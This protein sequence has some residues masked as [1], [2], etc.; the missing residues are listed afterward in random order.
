MPIKTYAMLFTVILSIM[1]VAGCGGALDEAETFINQEP[2]I[3][4]PAEIEN[5]DGWVEVINSHGMPVMRN[6][7][8]AW[9]RVSEFSYIHDRATWAEMADSAEMVLSGFNNDEIIPIKNAY[10]AFGLG[11]REISIAG[12]LHM[13]ISHDAQNEMWRVVYYSR[14]SPNQAIYMNY[15]GLTTLIVFSDYSIEH[16]LYT[17]Y[18]EYSADVHTFTTTLRIHEDMPEFTFT[19]II[20][21]N[22]NFS[23]FLYSHES[24]V[25][26]TDEEGDVIQEI[27]G[28]LH[29]KHFGDGEIRFDDFNFDGYLDMTML[30]LGIGRNHSFYYWLWDVEIGQFVRNEQLEEMGFVYVH[31]FSQRIVYGFRNMPGDNRTNYYEFHNGEFIRI[32][33]RQDLVRFNETH[34][35]RYWQIRHQSMTNGSVSVRIEPYTDE[36]S[37]RLNMNPPSD[38]FLTTWVQ[39]NPNM[40]VFDVRMDFLPPERCPCDEQRFYITIEESGNLIQE[41]ILCPSVM[42]YIFFMPSNDMGTWHWGGFFGSGFPN[43]IS[44]ADYNGDGYLDIA[45]VRFRENRL[46]I[47]PHYYWLW[48]TNTGQFVQNAQLSE[49]SESTSIIFFPDGTLESFLRITR[50]DYIISTLEYRNGDFVTVRSESVQT[51]FTADTDWD[52]VYS[53]ITIWCE[54]EGESFIV[55][56]Y[57]EWGEARRAR[58]DIFPE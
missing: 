56:R 52:E 21:G 23:D 55:Q 58:W 4:T 50:G 28:L 43:S 13:E 36:D 1:L 6:T 37:R 10:D 11:V 19:R 7:I 42:E 22:Y 33:E 47:D 53:N 24:K 45:I 12:L 26:I 15:D 46:L 30:H 3:D 54:I 34:G 8:P 39:I 31:P 49:L 38:A 16:I 2:I 20:G 29:C 25:I 44:F 14:R 40:P 5:A 17:E 32:L 27:S 48:D 51:H 9:Y 35:D 41:I 57:Y 18:P